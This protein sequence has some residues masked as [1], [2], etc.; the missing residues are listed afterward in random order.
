MTILIV[1][2][3][4]HDIKYFIVSVFSLLYGLSIKISRSGT[5]ANQSIKAHQ[6][7]TEAHYRRLL[8]CRVPLEHSSFRSGDLQGRP[9]DL[10]RG[11]V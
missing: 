9:K 1:M 10:W 7:Q 6:R 3:L 5:T 2:N 4:S 11:V 8:A